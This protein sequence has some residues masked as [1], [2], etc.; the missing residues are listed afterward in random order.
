MQPN[1][2]L[3]QSLTKTMLR[4]FF[5]GVITTYPELADDYFIIFPSLKLKQSVN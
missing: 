4:K 2:I 1:Y 5:E 3:S